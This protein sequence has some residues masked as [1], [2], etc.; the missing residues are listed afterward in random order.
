MADKQL[1]TCTGQVWDSGARRKYNIGD[2]MEI[3]PLSSVAKYFEGWKP[4]TEVYTKEKGKSG[5]QIIPG[6]KKEEEKELDDDIPTSVFTKP[7]R[8]VK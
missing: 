2:R 8:R 4:G 6:G 3:D 7:R 1:V 5:T